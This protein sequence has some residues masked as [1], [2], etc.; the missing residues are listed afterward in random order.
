MTVRSTC[1]AKSLSQWLAAHSRKRDSHR[2]PVR[3][4]S[5]VQM[6]NKVSQP[7]LCS[8]EI[9]G[10]L[11]IPIGRTR[12]GWLLNGLNSQAI[13][14]SLYCWNPCKSSLSFF[15]ERTQKFY[16]NMEEQIHPLAHSAQLYTILNFQPGQIKS[17]AQM[18]A[19]TTCSEVSLTVVGCP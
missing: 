6:V 10:M 14:S 3:V 17:W 1:S 19:R 5:R 16:W 11:P 2:W 8:G 9:K 4:R 13:F 18:A 15:H 7:T 12:S